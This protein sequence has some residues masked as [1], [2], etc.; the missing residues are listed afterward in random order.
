MEGS[1]KFDLW[2]KENPQIKREDGSYSNAINLKDVDFSNISED[3][4]VFDHINFGYDADFSNC[5]FGNKAVTFK[6][7]WFEGGTKFIQT[8]FG[9]SVFYKSCIVSGHTSFEAIVFEACRFDEIDFRGAANFV[10]VKFLLPAAFLNCNFYKPVSFGYC[11]FREFVDFSN[12]VFDP[13]SV[14]LKC[15][16]SKGA[17]FG[18]FTQGDIIGGPE[19]RGVFSRVILPKFME[20]KFFYNLI[21]TGRNIAGASFFKSK[22]RFFPDFLSEENA[23]KVDFSEVDFDILA[24]SKNEKGAFSNLNAPAIAKLRELRKIADQNKYHSLDHSLYIQEIRALNRLNSKHFWTDTLDDRLSFVDRSSALFQLIIVNCLRV[25]NFLYA[26]LSNYGKSIALP[27]FW[28]LLSFP[29]FYLLYFDLFFP[30]EKSAIAEKGLKGFDIDNYN[31]SFEAMVWANGAPFIG[32]SLIDS[33]LK[34]FLFCPNVDNLVNQPIKCFPP[35]GYYLLSSL[36]FI[37]S[38]ILIFL[39]L[40]GIRNYYRIK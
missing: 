33:G 13:N 2:R 14:F 24:K 11:D 40:L 22:F 16:F 36:H 5:N 18:Q 26:I 6:T 35:D 27:I 1:E 37:I 19:G 34:K 28:Y 39:L 20:S 31:A 12:S 8:K 25:I 7:C 4:I 32:N 29:I 15:E 3:E 21:T 23:K 17:N 9:K 10:S 30:I 38:S